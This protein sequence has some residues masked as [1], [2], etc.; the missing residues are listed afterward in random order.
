MRVL[1]RRTH[2]YF[3]YK[4]NKLHL[5]RPTGLKEETERSLLPG[6][7][8]IL[9]S[10]HLQRCIFFAQTSTFDAAYL[11]YATCSLFHGIVTAVFKSIAPPNETILVIK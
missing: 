11:L 9:D 2:I 10:L 6:V 4:D 3:V 8:G 5:N 7:Y 1:A